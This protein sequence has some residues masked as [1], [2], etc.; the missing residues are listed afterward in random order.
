VVLTVPWSSR[1]AFYDSVED[2]FS[3]FVENRSLA[4]LDGLEAVPYK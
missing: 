3:R 1:L 4:G 2:T